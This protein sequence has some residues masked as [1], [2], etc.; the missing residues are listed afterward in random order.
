MRFSRLFSLFR[1]EDASARSATRDPE[2]RISACIKDDIVPALKAV[3]DRLVGEG[4]DARLEHGDDWAELRARNYNGL[5]LV[6]A[7]RGHVYKEAVVSLAALQDDGKLR[8]FPRIEIEQGGGFKRKYR[9]ARCRRDAIEKAA[10]SYFQ[11]FL[12][13][14]PEG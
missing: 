4:Y 7:A 10:K 8:R 1:S 14:T 6:Y 13:K 12:M 3:R 9:L 11:R 2:S 5:D